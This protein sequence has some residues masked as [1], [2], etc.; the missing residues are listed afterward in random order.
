[1]STFSPEDL[2]IRGPDGLQF[3]DA[4]GLTCAQLGTT[5]SKLLEIHPYARLTRADLVGYHYLQYGIDE[6]IIR[7]TVDGV[8]DGMWSD[9]DEATRLRESLTKVLSDE[10]MGALVQRIRLGNI[11][12]VD[13]VQLDARLDHFFDTVEE[14]D[15][16]L[17]EVVSLY[18]KNGSELTYRG[19]AGL[20][21][22]S[23]VRDNILGTL[24]T[25]TDILDLSVEGGVRRSNC[26][27]FII[28]SWSSWFAKCYRCNLNFEF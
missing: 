12:Q 18:P 8:E 6:D 28:Y 13:R 7:E 1:M 4:W 15:H 17:R 11:R 10:T 23:V 16:S 21:I 3:S 24:K 2:N 26:C 25:S 22:G 14:T 27:S 9:W 20:D 5:V 19:R